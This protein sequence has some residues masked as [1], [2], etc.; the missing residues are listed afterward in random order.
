MRHLLFLKVWI[1]AEAAEEVADD[2]NG[3]AV[4]EEDLAHEPEV[5]VWHLNVAI[6]VLALEV[7]RVGPDQYNNVIDKN[8]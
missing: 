5:Y 8:R 3:E 2:T 1:L 7:G 4:E 6:V